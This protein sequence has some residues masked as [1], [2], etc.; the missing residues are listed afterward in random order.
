M[1]SNEGGDRGWD[2]PVVRFP[3]NCPICARSS[4]TELPVSVIAE[5]L[6]AG[7][8]IRL[9]ARCHD[10]RWDATEL[11]V[12]QIREY[13]GAAVYTGPRRPANE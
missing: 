12:E 1:T 5:A 11:E 3:V 9:H 4:L 6:I 2:E 10:V 13:L 7:L 8:S